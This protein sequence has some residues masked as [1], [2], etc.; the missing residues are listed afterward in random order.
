M[1]RKHLSVQLKA[2]RLLTLLIDFLFMCASRC[3]FDSQ[4]SKHKLLL[5][6]KQLAQF[7]FDLAAELELELQSQA[8]IDATLGNNKTLQQAGPSG[9]ATAGAV[10]GPA[11]GS[12]RARARV[13]VLTFEKPDT[14]PGTR[15]GSRPDSRTATSSGQ[16]LLLGAAVQGQLHHQ[17]HAAL[18]PISPP[19]VDSMALSPIAVLSASGGGYIVGAAATSSSSSTSPPNDAAMMYSDDEQRLQDEDEAR[20]E[21]MVEQAYAVRQQLEEEADTM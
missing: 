12:P 2:A 8:S 15:P 14:R 6:L 9:V 18:S 16:P 7:N 10:A 19:S 5:E 4:V 11:A 20:F 21:A 3:I 1:R 17:P 13:D